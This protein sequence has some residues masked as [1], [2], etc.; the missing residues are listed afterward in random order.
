M[1]SVPSLPPTNME[2]VLLNATAVYL[3]WQPPTPEGLNGIMRNYHVIIRGFDM[4]NISRVL[5]N[6]TVDGNSPKLMLT[7]LTAGVTYSVSVAAS[8]K[9]GYGPYSAPSILR[10]DPSTNK[11]DQGYV[12]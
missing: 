11:L 7:N 8:T 12:R 6:M 4:H 1:Y 3:K 5:T 10:L 2:A 9:I